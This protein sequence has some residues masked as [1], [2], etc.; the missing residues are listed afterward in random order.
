MKL[1]SNITFVLTVITI[2]GFIDLF[3]YLF[4]KN[5]T[6]PVFYLVLTLSWWGKIIVLIAAAAII[7]Y[8]NQLSTVLNIIL[9][10]KIIKKF[11]LNLMTINIVAVV[12]IINVFTAILCLWIWAAQWNVIMIVELLYL[13]GIIWITNK[14]IMPNIAILRK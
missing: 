4:L 2:T 5:V 1:I 3:L 13:T 7:K 14:V 11:Q 10:K 9:T 6:H 8:T 12:F